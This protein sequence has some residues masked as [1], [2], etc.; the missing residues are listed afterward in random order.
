MRPG[1]PPPG[2]PLLVAHR[3]GN[4]VLLL[5]EAERIGADLVEVDVHGYHGR[6][7]VRHSKTMGPLPLLWDRWSLEPGW[8]PRLLLE[9][10]LAR[11]GPTTELMLDLKRAAERSFP[12]QVREAMRTHAPAAPYSVCSQNWDLLEH[13]RGVP[14]VRVIHSVGKK[15]MLA[16][17]L[18]RLTWHDRH[19]VA[20]HQ[21]LLTPAVVQHLLRHAPVVLSWPVNDAATLERLRSWGVNGFISDNLALLAAAAE[22][23][24]ACHR[25]SG[26]PG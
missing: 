20:V 24:R 17:V 22:A 21:R 18:A 8:R 7:E 14:G 13:F 5:Q 23:R 15:R 2:D 26:T 16:E 4:S 19:A 1:T 11:C 6:L 9:D 25:Q 10:V 3:A 12:A